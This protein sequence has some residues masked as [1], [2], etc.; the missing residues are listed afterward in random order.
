MEN[1]EYIPTPYLALL[2]YLAYSEL[3][4]YWLKATY[5]RD[6]RDWHKNSGLKDIVSINL[7]VFR[8]PENDD[9]STESSIDDKAYSIKC[10]SKKKLRVFLDNYL[11]NFKFNK[12]ISATNYPSFE[13][14]MV[15]VE[16]VWQ[17]EYEH[18]GK[19][20]TIKI[21]L[22][23]KDN[24]NIKFRICEVLFYLIQ[25]KQVQLITLFDQTMEEIDKQIRSPKIFP[26]INI[27]IK[28]LKFPIEIADT[29]KNW[30]EYKSLKVNEYK[31]NIIYKNKKHRLLAT[32]KYFQMLCYLIKHPNKKVYF[33]KI[34]KNKTTAD[35]KETI[36]SYQRQIE[37][38]LGIK[39]KTG[40]VRIK[41]SSKY[42]ILE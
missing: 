29:Y 11:N 30:I 17:K 3:P 32:A 19:S 34:L 4:Y 21:S 15:L 33:D 8:F 16:K 25:H 2:F 27:A 10:L 14:Q 5:F 37:K 40:N 20:F 12:L 31:G 39:E 6:I 41:L 35:D 13:K 22:N 7:I 38:R 26:E 9:D 23:E 36:R 18:L 24:F 42:I 28:F 1:K